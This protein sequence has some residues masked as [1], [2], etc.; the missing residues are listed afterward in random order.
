[1][2]KNSK[3]FCCYSES[4]YIHTGNIGNARIE[5]SLFK[6]VDITQE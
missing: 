5:M 1:M 3:Y 4:M 6:L 2:G